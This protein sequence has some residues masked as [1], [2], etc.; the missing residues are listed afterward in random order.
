MVAA[1]ALMHEHKLLPAQ[2]TLPRGLSSPIENAKIQII[3]FF[4]EVYYEFFGRV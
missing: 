1:A 2:D 4:K 3:Y